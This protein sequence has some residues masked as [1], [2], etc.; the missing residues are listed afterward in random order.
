LR[1]IHNDP[2]RRWSVSD[3]AR[4]AAV[5]RSLFAERFAQ[6]CGEPPMHY[7]ARWRVLLA[8]GPLRDRRDTVASIAASVGYLSVASFVRAF[9]R[10]IGVSPATYRR[11]EGLDPGRASDARIWTARYSGQGAAQRNRELRR[12]EPPIRRRP[13]RLAT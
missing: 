13:S 4:E 12:S 9:T 10:L 6:L 7:V 3:L 8:T 2:T 11:R 1:A 5:S